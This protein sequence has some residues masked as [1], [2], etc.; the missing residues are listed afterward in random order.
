M[1]QHR[2]GLAEIQHLAQLLLRVAEA[3]V[4]TKLQMA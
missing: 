1:F 4:L 3:E 2:V